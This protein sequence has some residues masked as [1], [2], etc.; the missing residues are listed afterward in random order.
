M[1]TPSQ[2]VGPYFAIRVPPPGQIAPFGP[3]P[4][5]R[6]IRIEGRV[7]DGDGVPV[8][9]ALLET[10]QPNAA[11]HFATTPAAEPPGLG[12][13][14]VNAAGEWAIETIMPGAIP[15]PDGSTQ[16]PHLVMGVFARG[17]LVR[18]VTR[19]Y[20]ADVGD[21]E[22]DGVLGLVPAARRATLI[23]RPSGEDRYRFDVVLQGPAETVFFAI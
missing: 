2:T 22:R 8:P 13:V 11:G 6:R 16:A 10:W 15:G 9:D 18:L 20:F 1:L 5:G 14:V 7:L 4:V 21:L 17:L 23:A 19:I 12:R 3:D